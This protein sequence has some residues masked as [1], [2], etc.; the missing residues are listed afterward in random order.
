MTENTVLRYRHQQNSPRIQLLLKIL[1]TRLLKNI[2]ILKMFETDIALFANSLFFFSFIFPDQHRKF[3]HLY[4]EMFMNVIFVF[5]KNF[6]VFEFALV[7]N[8]LII[9]IVYINFKISRSNQAIRSFKNGNS[10]LGLASD[11]ESFISRNRRKF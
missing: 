4:K 9:H 2:G 6:H 1:L 11:T 7:V 10:S 5:S 8:S 3:F